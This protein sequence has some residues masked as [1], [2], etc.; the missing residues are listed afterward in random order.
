MAAALGV[1]GAV[2]VPG[3]PAAPADGAVVDTRR[4]EFRWTVER[5]EADTVGWEVRVVDLGAVAV[6][7]DPAARGAVA[8][9][10]LPDDRALTWFV[11]RLRSGDRREDTRGRDRR[12]L[13][14]AT[15]PAPP[16]ITGGPAGPTAATSP[17]FSW[18]GDRSSSRWAL[19]SGGATVASGEASTGGGR[20]AAGPLP[21]GDYVLRVAQV[22]LAGVAGP[23]AE[24]AFTVDTRPPAAPVFAAAPSFAA[25]PGAPLLSWTGEP[26]ARS[27]WRVLASGG[28][29]VLGPAQTEA[30]S[31]APGPL[32]PGSY[33]FEVRQIDA[34]GNAGGWASAPFAVLALARP[35]APPPAAGVRPARAG[36]S[37]RLPAVR[38]RLLRPRAGARLRVR[39]PMLRWASGPSGTRLYN[40]QVFR[41]RADGA[42][43][44]VVSAFPRRRALRPPRRLAPGACYVWRVWPYLAAGRF[45]ARPIGVSHFCVERRR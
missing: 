39:R 13:T 5:S 41:A 36:A 38:A 35:A 17:S 20:A 11:R 33:L 22:S 15:V 1:A 10:D 29:V 2:A 37:L 14:V 40:V 43:A 32:E 26:G 24:R 19:V 30:T 3:V 6:V 8:A 28:R 18:T 7:M 9:A 12:R 42:L 27:E 34:A 45:A 4:P 23:P 25:G 21:D 44:K 16:V 31:V